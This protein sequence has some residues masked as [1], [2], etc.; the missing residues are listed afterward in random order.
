M[1][2]QTTRIQLFIMKA[3]SIALIITLTI[4]LSV[5]FG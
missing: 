4:V 5:L 1:K 2:T 3:M